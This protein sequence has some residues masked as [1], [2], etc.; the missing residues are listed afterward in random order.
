MA[1]ILVS[2]FHKADAQF[3]HTANRAQVT[4]LW[5]ETASYCYHM[6]STSTGIDGGQ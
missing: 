5:L 2:L 4:R 1:L 6:L 3:L